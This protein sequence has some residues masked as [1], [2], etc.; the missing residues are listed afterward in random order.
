MRPLLST[1]YEYRPLK[2]DINALSEV[3]DF[4]GKF[5]PQIPH[6]SPHEMEIYGIGC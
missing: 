2:E 4:I 6:F 3:P 1:E 5:L